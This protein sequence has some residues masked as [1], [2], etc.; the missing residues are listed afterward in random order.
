MLFETDGEADC[1]GKLAEICAQEG[2][3][4]LGFRDVPVEPGAVGE[5]ARS[6]MPRIRQFFVGRRGGDGMD[7][8][9]KLYVI[10]RRLHKETEGS[11]GC[12]VVSLSSKTVIY[13][14]L[15][16]GRQLDRFYATCGTR[17]LRA[18]SRW[19]TSGSRRTPWAPGSSR[20][21]TGLSRTTARSTPSGAT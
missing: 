19:S 6:V 2:Q 8:E 10:R 7:F 20:T 15:L 12:Y 18:L 11:P 21:P 4:L 3:E 9:R 16:K 13:K 14:G 1:G 5:V 17:T